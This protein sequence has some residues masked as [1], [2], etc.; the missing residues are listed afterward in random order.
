MSPTAI[1]LSL[2]RDCPPASSYSEES[3]GLGRWGEGKFEGLQSKGFD[4]SD[5]KLIGA[6]ETGVW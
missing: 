1:V 6:V 4:L 3:I 5:G 2:Q